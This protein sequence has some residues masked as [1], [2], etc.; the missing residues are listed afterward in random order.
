MAN[1]ELQHKIIALVEEYLKLPAGSI[2]P[3][4]QIADVDE[5]DSLAHVMIIGELEQRLGVTIP[6]DDAIELSSM[7]ELLEKAGCL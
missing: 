1:M 7:G 5:W 4:T 3:D 6:L 2:T